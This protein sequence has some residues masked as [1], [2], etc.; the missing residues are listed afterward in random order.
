MGEADYTTVC[1]DMRLTSGVLWPMPITLDV[2]EEFAADIDAG[3]TIA[4]RDLEGVL[5]GDVCEV[6]PTSG[7][8]TACRKPNRFMARPMTPTRQSISS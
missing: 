6:D 2:T 5:A 4:L 1:Q 7:R 3:E 8:P